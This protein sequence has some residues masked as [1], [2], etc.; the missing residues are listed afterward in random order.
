MDA[1]KTEAP[2]ASVGWGLQ[3]RAPG[4]KA[5]GPPHQTLELERAGRGGLGQPGLGKESGLRVPRCQGS[6]RGEKRLE[7]EVVP[8]CATSPPTGTEGAFLLQRSL[9]LS[10]GWVCPFPS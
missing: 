5:A 4:E 7:G 8:G 9:P 1:E 6:P 10:G 2:C 3:R